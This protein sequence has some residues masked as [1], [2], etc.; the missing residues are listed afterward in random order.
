MF[1]STTPVLVRSLANLHQSGIVPEDISLVKID[2][3]GFDLEVVRGMGDYRY[4][5]VM[6]EFWDKDM[7]FA[8]SGLLYTLDV[9]V[10]EMRARGYPWHIVMYRVWGHDEMAYYANYTRTIP[11]SWGNV[12]FFRDYRVFGEAQAW[13]SAVMTRTYFKPARVS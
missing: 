11:N 6:A 7:E 3:E 12:C 8:Q 13:C 5:V 4:P 10:R 1:T 9:L 2:T